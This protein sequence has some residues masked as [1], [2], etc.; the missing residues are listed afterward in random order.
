MKIVMIAIYRNVGDKCIRLAMVED[1]S[2]FNY[3]TRGTVKEH[4]LFG[5]RVCCRE[6]QPGTRQSIG[7]KDNPFDCHTYVRADGLCGVVVADKEYPVR[8]AFSLI[9]K[10][11]ADFEKASGGKWTDITEDQ[12]LEPGFMRE[13]S[14]KYQDPNE[15]DK[16]IKIQ[17]NLDDIKDIM[18]KNI[19]E[20]LKRGENLDS[21]MEKSEDLSAV[22]VQF[23]KKAKQ[24]NQ[25]CKYY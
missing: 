23:Y 8:V 14:T 18:H 6:I 17:K 16:L 25:C 20:V 12:T 9:N 10:E 19:E 11:L 24:T 5:T 3:F 2:Q 1:L 15:A 7:M 21:L 22:S 13:D 4:L